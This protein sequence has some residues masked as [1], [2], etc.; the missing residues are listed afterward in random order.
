[1][2]KLALLA[3]LVLA[4]VFW[5][6]YKAG[7]RRSG[8]TQEPERAGS[9]ESMV[10]CLHCGVHLPRHDAVFSVSGKTYCS[11]AHQLASGEKV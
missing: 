3:L 5:L 2:G 10:P 1:M 8:A 11:A 6:R 9:V 4:V 7:S